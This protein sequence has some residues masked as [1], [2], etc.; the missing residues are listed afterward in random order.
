LFGAIIEEKG[1]SLYEN[2]M[3]DAKQMSLASSCGCFIQFCHAFLSL[4]MTAEHA[5]G[6]YIT[7][8][9]LYPISPPPP[10]STSMACREIASITTRATEHDVP[11]A[12]NLLG[13]TAVFLIECR[14]TFQRYVLPPS[15][16]R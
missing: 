1:M 7:A 14:P 15:S 5:G 13:C 2:Q 3:K 16:G 12:Q 6:D 10:T 11:E 4:K 8:T 9:E